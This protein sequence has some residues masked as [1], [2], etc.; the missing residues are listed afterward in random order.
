MPAAVLTTGEADVPN[1]TDEPAAGRE[2]IE[3][4]P[5]HLVQFLEEP[6]VVGGRNGTSI[7]DP[8]TDYLERS[9]LDAEC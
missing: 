6:V 9:S 5:P 2:R 8:R 1:D 4:A 7:I 3:A